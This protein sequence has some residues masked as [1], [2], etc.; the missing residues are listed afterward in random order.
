MCLF[1]CVIP[2]WQ[3]AYSYRDPITEFVEALYVSFD[4]D[5]AREK[6]AECEQVSGFKAYAVSGCSFHCVHGYCLCVCAQ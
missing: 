2:F 5:G 3:E 6:L 1:L 4:F